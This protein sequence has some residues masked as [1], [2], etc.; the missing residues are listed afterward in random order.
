MMRHSRD[1]LLKQLQDALDLAGAKPARWPESVR[2]RLSAFVETDDDAAR[3]FAEAKALDTVLSR[4]S[5]GTARPELELRIL[6][7]ASAMPQ[8]RANAA[9]VIDLGGAR[10]QD[11]TAVRAPGPLYRPSFLGGAALLAASLILGIF[12]GLSGQAIPTLRNI[13]RLAFNGG[14]IGI[15]FSGSIFEPGAHPEQGSL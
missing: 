7:A 2:T 13:E 10:R 12:I 8:Q 6:A 11:R 3:M 15:S 9:G 14:D 5:T 1:E 4:A